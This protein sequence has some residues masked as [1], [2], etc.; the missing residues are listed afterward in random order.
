MREFLLQHRSHHYPS[1]MKRW[2][3]V[4]KERNLL[5]RRFV[6]LD[7]YWLYYARTKRGGKRPT[8]YLSAGI[9]GDEVGAT[10]GLLHWAETSSHQLEQINVVIIPC[11][12]PWGL[13]ANSRVDKSGIDLNRNFH[14]DSHPLVAGMRELLRG[15][16]FDLGI[17]LHEDYDAQ[18]LYVYE[19]VRHGLESWAHELVK[20]GGIVIPPDPRASIDGR[21]TSKGVIRRRALPRKIYATMPESLYLYSNNHTQ[22]SYTVETP[23]EFALHDRLQTHAD[24]VSVAVGKLLETSRL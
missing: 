17:C 2:G 12:N 9:H 18:G 6:Q 22:R 14:D 3:A 24:F 23:S 13:A 5:F 19:V 16:K 1:L 21:R 7:G 4:A 11:L 15:R 8:V 20:E 10:E